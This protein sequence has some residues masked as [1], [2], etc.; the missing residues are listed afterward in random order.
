MY[1]TKPIQ[2]PNQ[3]NPTYA[4]NTQTKS[5]LSTPTQINIFPKTNKTHPSIQPNQ[6]H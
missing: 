5:I 6:T 1:K 4:P 2:P 3:K